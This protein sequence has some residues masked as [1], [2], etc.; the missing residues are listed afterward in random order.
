[1]N[2]LAGAIIF[3][4]YTIILVLILTNLMITIICEH[5]TR[6]KL[7][8]T[9]AAE[10]SLAEYFVSRVKANIKEKINRKNNSLAPSDL[11]TQKISNCE[12]FDKSS[13]KLIH[14]LIKLNKKP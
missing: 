8:N 4:A 12:S 13:E 11:R 3:S 10:V 7:A 2:Y 9:H 5:F 1:M 14:F 6:T